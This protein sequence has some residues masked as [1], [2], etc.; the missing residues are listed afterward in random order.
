VRSLSLCALAAALGACAL[1]SPDKSDPWSERVFGPGEVAAD[2]ELKAI[3]ARIE[4]GELPKV[5]FNFDSAEVSPRS[6]KTL[7]VIADLMLKY[8]V[9]LWVTAHTC[10]MGG[11]SYNLELS[12][13]RAKAVMD[14]LV[15]RG[16]E[17]PSI[18]YRGAGAAEPIADNET[19]EGRERNRRVEFRFTGRDW[20][21]VY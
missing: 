7:D 13:R 6:D 8:D 4:R 15:R 12:G 3:Q 16:V 18:R 21:T 1:P 17:P 11:E 14:Q 20:K 19:E 9:K 10:S 2:R 5:Q